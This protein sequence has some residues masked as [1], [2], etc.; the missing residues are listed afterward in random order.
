M[1]MIHSARNISSTESMSTFFAAVV[2]AGQP[3]TQCVDTST[4]VAAG[5]RA[6]VR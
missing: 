2:V 3:L 1:G 5:N 4:P 6:T